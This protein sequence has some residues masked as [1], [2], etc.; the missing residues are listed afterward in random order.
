MSL[1]LYPSP[2][3]P[4]S[5]ALDKLK[6]TLGMLHSRLFWQE[7]NST[8]VNQPLACNLFLLYLAI[9]LMVGPYADSSKLSYTTILSYITDTMFL[10]LCKA[11]QWLQG[12]SMKST[13]W[14]LPGL[15][16]VVCFYC[17]RPSPNGRVFC[18][19]LWIVLHHPSILHHGHH[20]PWLKLSS[21]I[22][23]G[24]VQ[25]IIFLKVTR[26]LACCLFLLYPA[27][28]LMVES[29]ADSFELS[30]STTLSYTTDTTDTFLL[31]L[32]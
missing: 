9:P 19:Q 5:L 18:Q 12:C 32:G 4:S 29:L 20:P 3:I 8:K 31:G 16:T 11:P 28:A 2:R 26:H 6:I 30:Y 27:R 7:I 13:S 10:G 1:A 24:V 14:W 21:S 23:P 17:I 25:N 15:W 22:T